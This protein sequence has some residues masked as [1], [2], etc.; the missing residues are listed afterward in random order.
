MYFTD[1]LLD[2]LAGSRRWGY[3][4]DSLSAAEPAAWTALAL[5]GHGRLD[6]AKKPLDWLVRVQG[7]DGSVGVTAT[8]AS[9]RWPTALAIHAWRR[10]DL[11][12]GAS[13]YIG[14]IARA[15]DWAL[16]ARG[17]TVRRNP[18][19]GHDASL[20][21]WPWV[22]GTHSWLE[23]T[24]LFVLALSAAGHIDHPRTSEA[25]RLLIDRLL[26][27]GGCNYGN[28]IVLGQELLPHVQPTGL[29]MLA[30][31]GRGVDDLR[32]ERSLDYLET[33]LNENQ[34]TAS[35]CY[36]LLGLTANNRRPEDAAEWLAAAWGRSKKKAGSVYKQALVALAAIPDASPLVSLS[37]ENARAGS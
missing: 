19:V 30:L 37:N 17:K 21:G 33:M 3:H 1:P 20:V 11:V 9:P 13:H 8:E 36:G 34:P 27:G 16:A 32:F 23:P 31:A 14:R 12:T 35:L 26:P 15:V 28:S 7:S 5:I 22:V 25:V 4:P 10:H 6:A 29:A 18:Q 2:D 24:A